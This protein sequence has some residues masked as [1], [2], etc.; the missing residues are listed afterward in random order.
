MQRLDAEGE[1]TE[2]ERALGMQATLAEPR[3]VLGK[4]VLRAVDD[5]EIFGPA[6]LH[7]RL[8]E[9]AAPAGDERHRFHHH[10]LAAGGGHL[11]PPRRRLVL[12]RAIRDVHDTVPRREQYRTPSV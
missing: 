5:T 9:S 12:A 4:R 8:H 1:L 2:R 7:G 10:A 3:Q 11:L 6:T